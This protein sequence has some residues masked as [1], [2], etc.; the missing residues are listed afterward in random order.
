MALAPVEWDAVA[1][2]FAGRRCGICFSYLGAAAVAWLPKDAV[3][4][5]ILV[6]LIGAAIYTLK[7]KDFGRSTNQPIVVIRSLSPGF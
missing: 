6:M 5:L 4:P 1:N 3:R 7:R 2:D